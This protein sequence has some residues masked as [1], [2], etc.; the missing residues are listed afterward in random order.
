MCLVHTN[1]DIFRTKTFAQCSKHILYQRVSPIFPNK[2]LFNTEAN[3]STSFTFMT[4][5]LEQSSIAPILFILPPHSFQNL[6]HVLN[7]CLNWLKFS[8]DVPL[9][10]TSHKICPKKKEF[11]FLHIDGLYRHIRNN[12]KLQYRSVVLPYKA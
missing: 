6:F 10:Q 11:R 7:Q 3:F 9:N 8:P 4:A 1:M 2:Q 5:F 12:G